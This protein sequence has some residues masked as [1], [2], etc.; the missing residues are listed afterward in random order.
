MQSQPF[1]PRSLM[2]AG[3]VA[4]L[5]IVAFWLFHSY[6]APRL[7]RLLNTDSLPSSAR[8]LSWEHAFIGDPSMEYF[9]QI[10]PG[11]IP[12]LMRGYTFEEREPGE[13]LDTGL[14][15]TDKYVANHPEGWLYVYA[16]RARGM[17]VIRLYK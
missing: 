1:I 2:V 10:E 7:A 12:E 16:N 4:V 6:Q 13:V 3:L 14:V 15:V 5:G 17:V 8:V 11:Q 9:V